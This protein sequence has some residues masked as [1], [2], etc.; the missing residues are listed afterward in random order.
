[1]A[2]APQRPR[3]RTAFCWPRS[4]LRRCQEGPA[5]PKRSQLTR[6]PGAAAGK[7]APAFLWGLRARALAARENGRCLWAGSPLRALAPLSPSRAPGLSPMGPIR[8]R[9][10]STIQDSEVSSEQRG[11]YSDPWPPKEDPPMP[12][13]TTGQKQKQQQGKAPRTRRQGPNL[14]L[15]GIPNTARRR[16]RDLKKLAAAMERVREWEIRQL[17]NIEEA[18][19]HEL[20]I[21][22]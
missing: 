3:V 15:P 16:R 21:D 13:S 5:F 19:Q 17:Q 6:S 14:G 1:M 7:R 4:L 22:N 10:L 20:T 8:K 12:A 9:Q 2:V 11:S 18:T